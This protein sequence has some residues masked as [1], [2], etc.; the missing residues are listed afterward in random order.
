MLFLYFSDS[1]SS[2]LTKMKTSKYFSQLSTINA[3]QVTVQIHLTYD[4]IGN[5]HSVHGTYV[6][7]VNNSL[8]R[9]FLHPCLVYVNTREYIIDAM[10]RP[11]RTITST[12]QTFW[13][14][15]HI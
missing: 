13:L 14:V 6:Q 11:C 3:L 8:V 15:F 1:S 10:L 5:V 4:V 9:T 7:P 12:N 2:I